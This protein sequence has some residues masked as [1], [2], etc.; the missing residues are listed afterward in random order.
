MWQLAV[1]FFSPR[2]KQSSNLGEKHVTDTAKMPQADFC[3]KKR[4]CVA[5]PKYG[6]REKPVNERWRR[7]RRR[8]NRRVEDRDPDPILSGRG[9]FPNGGA[10][11]WAGGG[12]SSRVLL[13]CNI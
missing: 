7:R 2:L 13:F 6:Q 9:A 1:Y 12:G 11:R 5:S 10:G 4:P 3:R 8:R